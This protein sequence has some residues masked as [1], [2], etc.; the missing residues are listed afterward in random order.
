MAPLQ[1]LNTYFQNM[2]NL[3]D[4]TQWENYTT[5]AALNH[6]LITALTAVDPDSNDQFVTEVAFNGV[7][8]VVNLC[9][10]DWPAAAGSVW[11]MTKAIWNKIWGSSQ[12]LENHLQ[13]VLQ[14]YPNYPNVSEQELTQ[15]REAFINRITQAVANSYPLLTQ[16]ATMQDEIN[17]LTQR[18]NALEGH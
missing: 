14:N 3:Y 6:G 15:I 17:A 7:S 11:K 5:Q 10:E 13:A 18:I 8:A 12:S 9:L 4:G 2:D 1:N 16:I